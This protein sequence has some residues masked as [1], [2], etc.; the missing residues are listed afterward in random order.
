MEKAQQV[1]VC[2]ARLCQMFCLAVSNCDMRV[3]Y[4]SLLQGLISLNLK[5][6]TC[7]IRGHINAV[8]LTL[9][10]TPRVAVGLCVLHAWHHVAHADVIVIGE[11][12]IRLDDERMSFLG[13]PSRRRP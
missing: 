5:V 2:D 6:V 1:E 10:V 3:T 8:P 11:V 13:R 12:N 9:S 4:A 7:S